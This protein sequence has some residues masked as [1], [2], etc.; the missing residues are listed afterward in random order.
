M[1]D[2]RDGLLAH[3]AKQQR[4]LVLAT[5]TW[6]GGELPY[7]FDRGFTEEEKQKIERAIQALQRETCVRFV[8]RTNQRNYINVKNS[9]LGCAAE[10]GYFNKGYATDL[11]LSSPS[12]LAKPGTIQHEF[13]HTLGFWHEHTRPDR[14]KYVS[15]IWKNIAK[16]KEDNFLAR[17][18]EEVQTAGAPYDYGSV[19]HYP[20]TAFSK[21]GISAT[22]VPREN[23]ALFSIGQ[24]DSYSR[25]DLAKLNRLYKC[26][27]YPQS[28]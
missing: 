14:D 10:V 20:S 8:R 27:G 1:H 3:P 19:M 25:V 21:D 23:K 7:A 2:S 11:H 16:G 6:P 15:I 13:L 9:G 17:P 26:A 5:K 22:I 24:R 18:P 12:C 4:N 28:F